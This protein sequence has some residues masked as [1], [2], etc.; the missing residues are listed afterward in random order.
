MKKFL[1]LFVFLLLQIQDG[2][3]VE[4]STTSVTISYQ[5]GGKMAAISSAE[6]FR[7]F[8]AGLREVEAVCDL[9]ITR[10]SSGGRVQ[11]TFKPQSEMY[12]GA[13]GNAY[14]STRIEFNNSRLV[15]AE[16]PGNRI[17]QAIMIHEF[18][19]TR[20]YRGDYPGDSK[21]SAD[22]SCVMHP[23]LTSTTMSPKTVLW[24]QRRFGKP[25]VKFYP[26]ERQL[27]GKEVNRL[28]KE[29]KVL[30]LKRRKLLDERDSSTDVSYRKAKQKEILNNVKQIRSNLE[31][32]VPLAR[33]W[34]EVNSKW[35]KVPMVG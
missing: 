9:K 27:I 14:G 7:R 2:Q 3:V 8:D 11:V 23:N 26:V 18:L 12:R 29:F 1:A 24:L 13:L 4:I 20:G 17:P 22:K 33:K 21:H 15:G 31:I 28:T 25:L 30:T 16:K 6:T 19:H 10:L 34:H 5:P 35:K 32:L